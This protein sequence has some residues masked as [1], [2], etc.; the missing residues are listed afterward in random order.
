MS[1]MQAGP[2]LLSTSMALLRACSVLQDLRGLDAYLS[3]AKV[4]EGDVGVGGDT[5]RYG[6][7]MDA[8]C[9]IRGVMT[10]LDC[11]RHL[12]FYRPFSSSL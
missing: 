11:R 7:S 12:P 4:D 2:A 5:S 8:W 3:N 10:L 1:I 9:D 6:C